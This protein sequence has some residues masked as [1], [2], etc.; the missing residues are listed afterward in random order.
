MVR[1]NEK[2]VRRIRPVIGE[3]DFAAFFNIAYSVIQQR[4][5]RLPQI[6]VQPETDAQTD[7]SVDGFA[8]IQEFL[9]SR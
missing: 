5:H 4:Y 1:F 2:M 9:P 6:A 7:F 3:A 8:R